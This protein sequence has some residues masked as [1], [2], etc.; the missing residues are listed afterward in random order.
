MATFK[1]KHIVVTGG[2]TGIGCATALAFAEGG[3]AKVF[4]TGRRA[5]RL[6]EVVA[7]HPSIVAVPADVSTEEGADLVAQA[8][9]ADGVDVLVHNAGIHR[10]SGIERITSQD[11][12]DI[13]A[14][15]VIGPVLLTVKLVPHMRSPGSIIF[16]SSVAGRNAVPDE[17]IYGASKAAVDSLTRTWALELAPKGIRVN[18]VAPGLTRTEVFEANGMTSEQVDFWFQR[19]A[20][21]TPLG[22]CG[23]PADIALW[24]TRF[25]EDSSSWVTGQVIVADGGIDLM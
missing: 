6:D 11:A 7:R 8:V 21:Q 10:R 5:H 22:R 9:S 3:A 23:E 19:A 16:V 1:D 25:A 13:F 14:T 15:N 2:G 18:A 24:I 17:S 20:T 4:I 12:R